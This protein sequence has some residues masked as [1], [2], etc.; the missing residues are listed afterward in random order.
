MLKIKILTLFPE[1]FD[2][3]LNNSIIK[4][5]IAKKAV[6]FELIN[7]RDYTLDKHHR[8][9]DH[10]FGGGAGLIMKMQPLSDCLEKNRTVDSHVILMSPLG[11]TYNQ[12]TAK[13]LSE[14]KE[15]ILVCGHYEGIDSRF[16]KKCDELISIGD[17]I[18]TGGEIA[19]LAIS[20]S[21]TRLLDGA[22][23]SESTKEESFNDDLLEY[24]QY[25]FPYDYE[26]DKAPDILFSGNHLAVENYHRR[27]ALRLTKELRPDLFSKLQLSKSDLKRLKELE[28]GSISKTEKLALEKGERFI[29]AQKNKAD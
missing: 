8:V 14:E 24:P 17:Y 29:I 9:D 16:N 21:V 20:D 2:S 19:A 7:I 26:G 3:F 4:R 15:L 13:R 11:K 23:S 27:E 12:K 1:Y 25:T 6:E 22:I 28:T 10:P 18:T 5:A